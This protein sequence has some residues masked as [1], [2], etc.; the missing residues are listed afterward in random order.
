MKTKTNTLIE[1]G[2]EIKVKRVKTDIINSSDDKNL[3]LY[4]KFGGQIT[5]GMSFDVPY[6]HVGGTAQ[7]G[8][9]TEEFGNVVLSEDGFT[10]NASRMTLNSTQ[11]EL[12]NFS[13]LERPS[14]PAEGT[15]I[16]DTTLKKCILYNGT[17]WVNLDGTV[18]A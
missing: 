2:Q 8:L 12:G 9:F 16:Y 17:A 18:L 6:T 14:S 1:D 10:I 13:T 3:L 15:L 5:I 7:A 11:L 4:D